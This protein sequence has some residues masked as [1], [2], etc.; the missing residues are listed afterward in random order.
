MHTHNIVPTLHY[1]YQEPRPRLLYNIV[2]PIKYNTSSRLYNNT[3]TRR[4]YVSPHYCNILY[5]CS[6]NIFITTY[7]MCTCRCK[8]RT[9]STA[10]TEVRCRTTGGRGRRRPDAYRRRANINKTFC[11]SEILLLLNPSCRRQTVDRQR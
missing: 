9:T 10:Y 5:Q 11:H 3:Y 8:T 2:L 4:K 1:N 7:V 6:Q